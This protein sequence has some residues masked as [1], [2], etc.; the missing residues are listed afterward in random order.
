MTQSKINIE[1]MTCQHCVKAV[2]VEFEDLNLDSYEVEIG[3]AN[4]L[5]DED[6]VNYESIVKA[7]EEA[8]YKVIA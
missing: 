2:E 1:G 6:K 5:Y 4:V 7:I 3:L 8:G